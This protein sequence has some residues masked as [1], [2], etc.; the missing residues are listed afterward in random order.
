MEAGAT[1]ASTNTLI[2]DRR[3]LAKILG[4]SVRHIAT[5]EA[6]GVIV[7]VLRGKGGRASTYALETVVPSYI[8][9]FSSAPAVGRDREARG[10]RDDAAARLMELRIAEQQGR[11]VDI[12]TVIR[13]GRSH[14]LGWT[15]MVRS[16]P[17]Q[18]VNTGVV[19][20]ENESRLAALCRQL[21]LEISK[22]KVPAD[23]EASIKGAA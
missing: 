2:V 8:T 5:L 21:L 14:V 20:R 16:L 4:V 22:W 11:L 12:E 6:D 3:Q 15:A 17:R 18:A 7:P 10:R 13:D 19:T 1:V 23:I 9:S